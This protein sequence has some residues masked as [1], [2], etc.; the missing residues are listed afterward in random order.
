MR[1][2]LEEKGVSLTEI[3]VALVISL[4][5][6]AGVFQ[7]YQSGKSNYRF[8]AAMARVQE[9]G[10]FAAE[11]I[12]RDARMADFW[13]CASSAAPTSMLNP[14]S[15]TSWDDFGVGVDGTNDD[16]LNGSDSLVLQGAFGAGLQL[17]GAMPTTSAVL[18]VT[19]NSGLVDDQIIL[20]S[21]CSSSHILQ[22]T[23]IQVSGQRDTVVH[24]AGGGSSPGNA[25]K[26]FNK[27]YGTDASVMALR[28]RTY[29]VAAGSDGE[30][31]LM[32]TDESGTVTEL[33]TGVE[34]LQ[35]TYGLDTDSSP[36]RVPNKYLSIDA[37][38]AADKEKI[39][40]IRL[41]VVAR[42]NEDDVLENAM[43]YS[44]AGVSVTATDKRLR[45]V[46]VST[47]AVRN[48]VL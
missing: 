36:D 20:V 23:N 45:H 8:S 29:S 2:L 18:S 6:L 37:I 19:R 43:T 13:G 10:R 47:I 27:S 39:V 1:S 12:S 17:T 46:F 21:D 41:E 25:T 30:P 9:A 7:V 33:V 11:T 44:L 4:F 15:G 35:I 34:N 24:N 22:I 3:L 14:S 40:T 26:N 5:L 42:S 16:G 38:T 32:L 31:S 28:S 48:R